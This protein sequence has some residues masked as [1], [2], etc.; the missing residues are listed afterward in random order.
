MINLSN[1][2]K[3]K[4]MNQTFSVHTSTPSRQWREGEFDQCIN[5]SSWWLYHM[6]LF[7]ILTYSVLT[8]VFTMLGPKNTSQDFST[9]KET[10][11]ALVIKHVLTVIKANNV[12]CVH[13]FIVCC[14]C[15]IIIVIIAIVLF[16]FCVPEKGWCAWACTEQESFGWHGCVYSGSGRHCC[17]GIMNNG[18]SIHWRKFIKIIISVEWRRGK[19]GWE[20]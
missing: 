18:Q 3:F 9:S 13:Q 17:S 16:V 8:L 6:N 14:I 7:L 4:V 1:I 5:W 12:T 15:T 11:Y 19:Q 20:V 2:E 10:K